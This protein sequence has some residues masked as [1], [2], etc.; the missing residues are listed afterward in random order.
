[1]A[2]TDKAAAAVEWKNYWPLVLACSFGFSLST[3]VS[4]SIGLFMGPMEAELGWTRA[5][6]AY[7]MVVSSTMAIFLN[8]VGG[9]MVDRWGSRSLAIPGILIAAAMI[10]S[11]GLVQS[12]TMWVALWFTFSVVSIGVKLTVWTAAVSN[13][14]HASRGLAVATVIAGTALTG[15]LAPPITNYLIDAYGWRHAWMALAGLWGTIAFLL[16][17]FFLKEP[18]YSAAS[19]AAVVA[20]AA[21][22]RAPAA[23]LPGLTMKEAA[24]SFPLWMVGA[25]TLL[26]MIFAGS[27]VIH[28]VPILIDA[29][30][31]RGNAALLASLA[32]IAGFFGKVVT[33][34]LMDRFHAAKLSGITLAF[35]SLG[36]VLLLEPFR[37]VVTIVIAM[38]IVGYAGGAKLQVTTYLTGRYGGLRNFG[39]IFGLM[40]S[41]IAIGGGFGPVVA[42][43]MYDRFDSYSIFLMAGIPSSLVA[44]ALV[45]FL[46]PY[47]DWSRQDQP[48]E[49]DPPG[50]APEP[51]K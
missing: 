8:P 42:G 36:F 33:G 4:H 48:E 23:P 45:F 14:F 30:V 46:G 47:P 39:K 40:N 38:L 16:A 20:D 26:F 51:A 12:V 34:A 11:Y 18:R 24:R 15:I 3:L 6:I 7:G 2:T 10:G 50:A 43:Y 22:G 9:A 37:H 44:G 19:K 25:S 35:A 27:M 41:L 21:A 49:K 31:D 13:T 32:A 17:V 5:E 29:G 1:M 28:Q